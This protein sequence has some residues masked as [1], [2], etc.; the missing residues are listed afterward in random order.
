MN[1]PFQQY[2]KENVAA[3]KVRLT[4]EE[5]QEVRAIAEKANATQG[6]RYPPGMQLQFVDTPPL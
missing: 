1:Y 2:L 6:E 4:K 3:V 5:L